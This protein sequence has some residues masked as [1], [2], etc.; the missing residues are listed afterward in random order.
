MNLAK[1]IDR[2]LHLDPKLGDQLIPIRD[3]YIMRPKR[4]RVYWKELLDVLNSE[5]VRKNPRWHEFRQIFVTKG[6]PSKIRYTFDEV[7]PTDSLIGT[8]PEN[9]ADRIRRY[10]RRIVLMAM[11]NTEA[12]MTSNTDE[13]VRLSRLN[14]LR[15]VELKR[16]WIALKDHFKLWDKNIGEV[17]IRKNGPL[18]VLVRNNPTPQAQQ[19]QN[20]PGGVVFQ[21]PFGAV[22]TTPEI[23]KQILKLLGLPMLPGMEDDA[24]E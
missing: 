2:L 21:T 7:N 6:K 22:Q 14:E 19:R 23:L 5:P 15:S 11:K 8:I 9:L 1:A 13:Q 3:K 20:T 10:D 12:E 18:L 4:A 17:L 24:N 16:I